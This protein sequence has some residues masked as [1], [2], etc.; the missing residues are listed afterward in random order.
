MGVGEGDEAGDDVDDVDDVDDDDADATIIG[1]GV[2]DKAILDLYP[3]LIQCCCSCG[4]VVFRFLR[5]LVCF[6]EQVPTTKQDSSTKRNICAFTIAT[7][8]PI[9][10][11]LRE[12]QHRE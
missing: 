12:A 11:L 4:G 10:S 2:G 1:G 8:F 7:P 9:S 3:C 5:R 6:P